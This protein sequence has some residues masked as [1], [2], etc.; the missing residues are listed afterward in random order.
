M[1][2]TILHAE[3]VGR[4]FRAADGSILSVL[5]GV[6]LS[7]DLDEIV[8]ILGSSGCGK[9]T[10]LNILA[11]LDYGSGHVHRT[12]MDRPGP[13]VAYM[14]QS[15][16][17]LP[18]R[19]IVGNVRLGLEFAGVGGSEADRRAR[20]ALRSVGLVERARS[21]PGEVSGGMRQRVALART[22]AVRAPLLLLDE[23][24]AHLDYRSR[25]SIARLLREH[26]SD[27]HCAAVIVTHAIDEAVLMADRVMVLA[28]R[29]ARIVATI[30][31]DAIDV[32][33]RR[34]GGESGSIWQHDAS[35]FLGRVLRVLEGLPTEPR[36]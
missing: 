23:P 6:S 8:C 32:V 17:L 20:E 10:L 28:G 27:E 12:D 1:E 13:Q 29:P 7:V 25:R 16:A 19:T 15:D 11:G 14:P 18:W 30:A 24:M 3:N 22:L 36:S 2:T 31:G 26:V 34:E 35:A 21:Y 9:T 4:E 5:A 33:A